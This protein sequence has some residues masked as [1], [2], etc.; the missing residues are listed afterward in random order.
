[1]LQLIIVLAEAEKTKHEW[2]YCIIKGMEELNMKITSAM[3]NKLLTKLKAEKQMYLQR[4]GDSVSYVV[5]QGEEAL[6]P[7][8][9]FSKNNQAIK[10]I[11]DKIARIKHA[12]NVSNALAKIDVEGVI[13]S[14]DEILVRMA[15]LNARLSVYDEL[16]KKLPKER[17]DNRRYSSQN[18]SVIEFSY[19]NYDLEEVKKEFEKTEHV[20][21]MMQLALDKY[22]QTV[23]FEID[24]D[25]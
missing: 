4:E 3:A 6:I 12:I 19:I 2:N 14:V 9:D 23:E 15:Q 20:I 21:M 22:N 24:V 17:L 5:A 11:D 7:E 25:F 13:Y 8:F 16:R 10:E 1:M 18:H